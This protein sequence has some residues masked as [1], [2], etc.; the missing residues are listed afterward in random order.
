MEVPN[1][2]GKMFP[3]TIQTL[4]NKPTCG[5]VFGYLVDQPGLA[6]RGRSVTVNRE[7]WNKCIACSEFDTCYRLSVATLLMEM[8]VKM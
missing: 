3:T 5:K 4:H 8:A 1:C 7:A 6:V 2:K